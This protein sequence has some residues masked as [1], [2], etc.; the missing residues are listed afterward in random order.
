[1]CSTTRW[2]LVAVEVARCRQGGAQACVPA[3]GVCPLASRGSAPNCPGTR[4]PT[5][6]HPTQ[7]LNYEWVWHPHATACGIRRRSPSEIA[8][9]LSHKRVLFMGDSHVRYLHNWVARTLG[10]ER[11]ARVG[12]CSCGCHGAGS[13]LAACASPPTHASSPALLCVS[14]PARRQGAGQ[15]HGARLAAGD[16]PDDGGG[17]GA[18]RHL[19]AVHHRKLCAGGVHHAALLV[20]R[21]RPGTGAGQ[22][23]AAAAPGHDTRSTCCSSLSPCALTCSPHPALTPAPIRRNDT[24]DEPLLCRG[25]PWPDVVVIDGSEWHLFTQ[26]NMTEYALNM[27]ELLYTL[28][29]KVRRGGGVEAVACV[30]WVMAPAA[31]AYLRN[32]GIDLESC[33]AFHLPPARY[34]SPPFWCGCRRRRATRRRNRRRASCRPSGSAC[35]TAWRAT[36]ATT[37]PKGPPITWTCSRSR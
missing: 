29:T 7:I 36:W 13:Y 16:Q 26:K 17:P 24:C 2:G 25:Q 15:V 37:S 23:R 4:M 18:G 21:R 5:T 20:R 27:W 32:A 1:M 6:P 28:Q 12:A 14:P 31:C 9:V 30:W 3:S 33:P 8:Q 10:G 34:P 22:G 35:T 19:A 11:A